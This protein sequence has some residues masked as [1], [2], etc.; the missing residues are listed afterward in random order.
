MAAV[1]CFGTL[2]SGVSTKAQDATAAQ[3]AAKSVG[4]VK[5]ISG[6]NITLTTEAGS[7]LTVV[8]QD[9]ARLLR[10]EP[11][12]TDLKK[13]APLDLEDLQPGDRILVRGKTGDDG[14]SLLAVSV[15]AMKK[16]DIAAKHTHER[17]EWQQHGVGGLVSAVDPAAGSIT[18]STAAGA[19]KTIAIHVTKNTVLRRYA[20]GSV[21]FDDAK[22]APLSEIKVA[23]QLRARGT[24]S[25]DGSEL[26]ADEIVSGSFQNIA[27]TISSIDA[28][29]GT[30]T[31]TDLATK[32][33]VT[34][35]IDAQTQLRKLPQP[36][37]QRIAARLKGAPADAQLAAAGGQKPADQAG[38]NG[39][40]GQR[41]GGGPGGAQGG[42]LQQAI[43]RMPASTLADLQK[44][45][46][47]MIVATGG[48]NLRVTAITLLAG[49]EPILEASP[50]SGQSILTPWSLGGAPSGD[51]ATP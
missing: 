23:D 16:A 47:V 33:P 14:K 21:K 28:G 49:V 2:S 48:E 18:I 17:Q 41:S 7:D 5:A 39:A 4:T 30:I 11:G 36:M 34:V 35:K 31:V 50:N 25:A 26:T 27:G 29:A 42:D 24:R 43:S 15:I 19:S 9:G 3:G 44:G 51:A 38:A 32:Q 8:V 10:I 13:A 40:G 12:E 6:K 45:D 22:P 20:P 46:A 1:F 37:A